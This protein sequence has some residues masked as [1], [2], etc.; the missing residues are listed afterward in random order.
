MALQAEKPQEATIEMERHEERMSVD[1]SHRRFQKTT[2]ERGGLARSLG[3]R[4]GVL[5]GCLRSHPDEEG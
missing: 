2:V 3:R 5:G 1:L 4:R